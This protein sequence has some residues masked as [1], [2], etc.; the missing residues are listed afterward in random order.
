[1]TDMGTKKLSQN[2]PEW[3]EARSRFATTREAVDQLMP[4]LLG[5][6]PWPSSS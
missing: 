6:L 5:H 4:P 1:M 3:V 2:L